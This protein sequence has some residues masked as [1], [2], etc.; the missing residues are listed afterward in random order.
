MKALVI[1]FEKK[2]NK[3]FLK[4]P[5][6]KNKKN[7]NKTKCHFGAPPILNIFSQKGLVLGLVG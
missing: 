7:K 3:F 1:S 5:M 2:Q 4:N 6:T